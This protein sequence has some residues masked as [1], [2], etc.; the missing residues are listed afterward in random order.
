MGN[1]VHMNHM[2]EIEIEDEIGVSYTGMGRWRY[3]E[4]DKRLLVSAILV[5][6]IS[7]HYPLLISLVI[8]GNKKYKDIN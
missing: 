7:I 4:E 5:I 3:I 1:I 6:V 8:I 2:S